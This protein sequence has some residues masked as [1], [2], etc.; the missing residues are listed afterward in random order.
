MS[1]LLRPASAIAFRAASMWSCRA[2]LCGRVPNSSDSATPTM[3][4]FPERFLKSVMSGLLLRRLGY[5]PEF[6]Q[7]YGVADIVENDFHFHVATQ[8]LGIGVHADN[9]GGDARSFF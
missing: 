2:D 1:F 3:A 4:N 6:R 9:I 7:R 5:R 8:V